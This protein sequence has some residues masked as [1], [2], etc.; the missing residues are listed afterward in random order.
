[1]TEPA[2]RFLG[3]ETRFAALRICFASF[4]SRKMCRSVGRSVLAML[5]ALRP[6]AVSHKQRAMNTRVEVVPLKPFFYLP[7]QIR[8]SQLSNFWQSRRKW[9]LG[10]L[11]EEPE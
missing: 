1:M 9:N 3:L 5:S 2:D 8:L 11:C 6:S 7:I 4:S 10:I